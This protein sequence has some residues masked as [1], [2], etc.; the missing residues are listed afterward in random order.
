MPAVLWA[1]EH[2]RAVYAPAVGAAGPV[3]LAVP[4]ADAPF[5][6]QRAAPIARGL[7]AAEPAVVAL[8]CVVV[9]P[10]IS[11]LAVVENEAAALVALEFAGAVR[12]VFEPAV[13]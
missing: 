1:A 10:A 9:A 4:A 11:T 13:A 8:L 2:P 7:V 5:V 6:E 3:V 12:A